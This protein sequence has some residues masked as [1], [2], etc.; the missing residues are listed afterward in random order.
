MALKISIGIAAYNAEKNIANILKSLLNQNVSNFE[1]VE[2]VVHSDM[3]TDRTVEIV[4][5]FNNPKVKIV[6]ALERK[7][8]AGSLIFLINNFVGDIIVTLN[9]DIKVTDP[10]FLQLL[11][12]PFEGN[13]NLGMVCG[14]TRPLP[15]KSFVES[16]INSTFEAYDK[17]GQNVKEGNSVFSVDGKIMVFSRKAV[18]AFKYPKDYRLMGNV[19]SYFYFECITKGFEY[20]QARNALAYYR[21]PS[22]LKDYLKWTIR[23]NASGQVLKPI[24]GEAI[25]NREYQSKKTDLIKYAL[26]EFLKNP[27]GCLF[28]LVTRVYI[29]LKTKSYSSNFEQQWEVV[30]TSKLID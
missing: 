19:D 8:F 7:G 10:N 16:A 23:N 5:S 24:Y 11:I 15:P 21:N 14:N 4:K 27:L 3:S 2:I 18:E 6:E 1:L 9:D 17:M 25:V 26:I 12:E 28:I 22:T 13:R 20:R 29:S 30:E